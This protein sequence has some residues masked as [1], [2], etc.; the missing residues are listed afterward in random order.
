[1]MSLYCD[2]AKNRLFK[3][4][5]KNYILSLKY[6]TFLRKLGQKGQVD[7]AL[8]RKI[9]RP[10]DISLTLLT[11]LSDNIVIFVSTKN[12]SNHDYMKNDI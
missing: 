3:G 12:C 10:G 6:K 9:A 7:S 8:M 1:M 5:W 2:T 4:R 11:F